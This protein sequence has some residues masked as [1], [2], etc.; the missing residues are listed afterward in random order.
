M[1]GQ[2][3]RLLAVVVLLGAVLLAP[4]FGNV[5]LA[6]SQRN[7]D[8]DKSVFFP[9]VYMRPVQTTLDLHITHI[10]L[11]QSVQNASNSVTLV[12]G[13]PA[14]LRVYAQ[15]N[16][17]N[18]PAVAEVTVR[19]QRGQTNLGSLTLGPQVVPVSPS[20]GDLQS[21]FNFDLPHEWLSGDVTLSATIDAV[22]TVAEANESNNERTE[23]FAFR[24]ILPLN[25][26]IVP[27]HYTHLPTGRVYAEAPH[28]PLSDWLRAAFPVGQVNV[29]YHTPFAFAGDLG[30]PNEWQRLLQELTTLWAAEVG[31]GSGHVYYGLI[32]VGN[33]VSDAWFT[34]GVSG[35]GWIGQRVSVGL[36]LGEA[37]GESA[38]HELG[39]NFGRR[40]APCGNPSSVDPAYPY[41]NATIG[42]Y[43]VDTIDD[44][45]L[46]PNANYDMMSYCGPEW[47]S[48]YTYEGLLQ[49]QLAR[50]GRTGQKG[51]SLL[52]RATLA[53]GTVT[54]LPA[55]VLDQVSP[56]FAEAVGDYSAE[57]LDESGNVVGAYPASLLETEEAGV[58]ARMLVAQV[59]AAPEGANAARFVRGS[60]I[61]SQRAF[62]GADGQSQAQRAAAG[63][64]VREGE[65]LSLRW[66]NNH[67][68]LVRFS[69]DGQRWTII[70]TDVTGGSFSLPLSHLP[71]TS[72]YFQIVLA[73]GGPTI[74]LELK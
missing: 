25:L 70:A 9:V 42:V 61:M 48:D 32:P 45:L 50:G 14:L 67:H 43:G 56:S 2:P 57:L 52:L 59:S 41:P 36:D 66:N 35:L 65:T 11:Y 23:R 37:T 15:A 10:G 73:D 64:L 3:T 55:Y 30:N 63:T 26:T 22:N 62:A 29:S 71:A 69:E 54:A 31:F 46:A 27:I 72:G 24:T 8:R 5:M 49:D 34:G 20:A 16:A 18:P 47:V 1:R 7:G 44:T 19:A 51:Q 21:T 39:H 74:A 17:A 60:E 38:G 6:E 12:A 4:R 40:H 58:S 13:K 53:D 28:D 68:A 33:G